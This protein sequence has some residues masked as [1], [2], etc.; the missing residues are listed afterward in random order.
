ME[1][2]LAAKDKQLCPEAEHDGKKTVKR[3]NAKRMSWGHALKQG[4]PSEN[5]LATLPHRSVVAYAVRCA[6][7]VRPRLRSVSDETIDAVD[8]AITAAAAFARGKPLT[9][10]ET[11]EAATRVAYM[12]KADPTA[13]EIRA[14]ADAARAADAAVRDVRAHARAAEAAEAAYSAITSAD[15]PDKAAA[16]ATAR[17]DFEKLVRRGGKPGNPGRAVNPYDGGSLG[18][19]W[20]GHAPSWYVQAKAE[21][22]EQLGLASANS[23]SSAELKAVKKQ[24]EELQQWIGV[25]EEQLTLAQQEIKNKSENTDDGQ[26]TKEID[27]L[28][29]S[30]SQ[31]E[32]EKESL[33][34]EVSQLQKVEADLQ[35]EA[36]AKLHS[37]D[38]LIDQLSEQ[39]DTSQQEVRQLQET[40]RNLDADRKQLT[41]EVNQQKREDA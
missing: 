32:S 16:N 20:H 9:F 4:R 3:K 12:A 21:L 8:R 40:N 34:A 10:E 37:R 24:R 39:L 19:L 2:L 36:N 13:D 41:A 26:L 35:K 31:L 15:T 23:D 14:A 30:V 5:E 6:L 18:D 38:A 29:Q 1:R 28:Q 17:L 25:L 33:T 11:R 22:D 27:R 7:R